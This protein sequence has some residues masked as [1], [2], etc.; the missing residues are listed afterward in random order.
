MH[1]NTIPHPTLTI[2]IVK[3]PAAETAGSYKILNENSSPA[4]CVKGI[5]YSKATGKEARKTDGAF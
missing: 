3:N 4:S 5:P 1:F 2:L